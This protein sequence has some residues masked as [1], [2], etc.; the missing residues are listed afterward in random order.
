MK[1]I[2]RAVLVLSALVLAACGGSSSGGS[3]TVV[4][5]FDARFDGEQF[6]CGRSFG[7]VGTTNATVEPVDLRFYVSEVELVDASGNA[8]AVALDDDGA[9]QNDG[10]ALVDF[11]DA[12]GRCSE[13]GTPQTNTVVRGTAPAGE[14]TAVRFVMGVPEDQN[15]QDPAAAPAPLNITT[16]FWNWNAGYKFIRFD[17]WVEES[18]EPFRVHIGSTMCE[19]D[20]RG[21]ATCMNSNRPEVALDNFSGGV[22]NIL[23]DLSQVFVGTNVEENAPDTSAG[24]Q[25]MPTD[26]DCIAIFDE[27]GLPFRGSTPGAQQVFRAE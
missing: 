4:L 12:T 20:G 1:N 27:F 3:E 19:G 22:A 24:C 5:N 23:M 6:A 18:G 25:S 7:N 16:L 15:H 21:N 10:V 8:V 17:N 9:W 13:R 14:Y 26:D 2:S 11:E